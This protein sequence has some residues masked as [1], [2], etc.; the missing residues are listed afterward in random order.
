MVS[1]SYT[2]L[3]IDFEIIFLKTKKKNTMNKLFFIFVNIILLQKKKLLIEILY[4]KYAEKSPFMDSEN[5]FCDKALSFYLAKPTQP[6]PSN[7]YFLT[8]LTFKIP[9]TSTY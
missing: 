5:R 9:S 2:L 8:F 7:R 1:I 6:P 4:T 3:L